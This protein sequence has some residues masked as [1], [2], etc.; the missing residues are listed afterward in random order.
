MQ[1][2]PMADTSRPLFPNLRFCMVFL[3]SDVARESLPSSGGGGVPQP[4][5][6]GCCISLNNPA[7][8]TRAVE[9]LADELTRS[10]ARAVAVATDVTRYDEVKRL[11]DTAVQAF[12]RIDVMINNAGLMPHSSLGS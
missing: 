2:R 4:Q 8:L 12:G 7:R 5:S 11:V 6:L 9:A 3:L 10:G 1:P